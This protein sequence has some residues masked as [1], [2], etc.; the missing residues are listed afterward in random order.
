[1]PPRGAVA[2]RG[3]VG[4]I[5]RSRISTCPRNAAPITSPNP[6]TPRLGLWRAA[7]RQRLAYP[8]DWEG[9]HIG[10]AVMVTLMLQKPDFKADFDAVKTEIRKGLDLT[11]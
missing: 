9:V 10:G 1:M 11:P 2:W 5:F 3:Y 4:P 8:S 6:P 7:C